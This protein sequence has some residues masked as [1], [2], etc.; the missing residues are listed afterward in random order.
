MEFTPH[1]Y[2]AHAMRFIE[3]HERSMMLLDMGLGKT[4]IALH[5]MLDLMYDSFEVSRALVIAPLRVARTVWPEELAKWDGLSQLRMSLVVG[6]AAERERALAA[7]A[8]VYVTN[9]ENVAWL[10]GLLADRRE[11]WPF[12]TVVI[13][14]LSSF[15][16]H[17]SRRWRAL[18]SVMP[19]VRRVVG[20]TGTP[21]PN[22]L[23]DLWA[24]AYLID[25]GERL[26]RTVGA[27]RSR[28]FRASRTN[29]Y[30]GVVYSWEPLPGAREEILAR[31]S[32]VAVSMRAVD[33]L[34]MPERVEVTHEVEMSPAERR[35]YDE[36]RRDMLCEL[37]GAE[38]DA[39]SA[40]A[41]SNKLLQMASGFAYDSGGEAR[42]LH[43]R[44]L[45]AL[46]DIVEQACGRPVLVAYWFRHDRRR[47]AERLAREG[48]G[49]RGIES[50]EDV[51]DW[52]AG[53]VPVALISPASAGH[54]LNMQAGGSTIVWF[55]PT[56]SLELYQQTNARLW[57]QGQREVVGIHHIVC[58]GTVDEDVMAAIAA[59]DVTQEA[60]V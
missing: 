27:F 35:A 29:P 4:A 46:C 6:S 15:K 34:D 25:G 10:V 58:R 7:D 51:R 3:S 19:R 45:D 53:S 48:V 41:L 8:D 38:V 52:N 39:G 40:A 60:L 44:K 59:K 23:C 50:D 13:D 11:P 42:E 55:T 1:A 14:E 56:W 9:R 32:D 43:S 33:H 31:L 17:R 36:M 16:S 26:G 30:T 57:R 20:L 28:G 12:D 18:R 54:G 22:G 5:A 2:Q 21:A 37:D 24:Q 49:A 47:I